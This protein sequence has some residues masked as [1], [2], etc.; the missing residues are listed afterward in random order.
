[1]PKVGFGLWKVVRDEAAEITYR[2]IKEG[3]RHLDCAADYGNEIEVGK[4]I[5][6]A[7]EEGLVERDDLWITSKLWNTFHAREHVE[8]GCS[9]S[10]QDLGLDYF[11][12]Y[13]V[14]FPIALQ[15]VPIGTRYPPE[16]FF[17]P[18]ADKPRMIPAKIPLLETWRGMEKLVHNGFAT[19]IGVCNYNTALLHDLISYAK[20]K[21]FALQIE[22]HPY[23]TQEPLIRLAKSYEIEV[24]AF[25]P[26][27]ALSYQE[28]GMA[29]NGES[30]LN[31]KP[32]L[33]AASSHGK[34]PAQVVLRWGIQRGTAIIPKSSRIDRMRENL[35]IMDFELT[36]NEMA[37]IGSL[38]KNRRFNDPG[39]FTETAFN[40]FYP[41]YD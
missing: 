22:S 40:T 15:Y 10:L 20:E 21:P 5:A 32:V 26:L 25:S 9:K 34:T 28:I 31:E 8:E 38:N 2:A 30:V 12:L 19:H 24:T 4:G 16:W 14:H 17:D 29:D 13:M 3:Y 35:S 41:I 33:S 18:G 1:M 11:D 6:R 36:D 23:L 7:I 37:D 27:A 39:Q